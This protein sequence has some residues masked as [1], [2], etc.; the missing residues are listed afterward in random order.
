LF[1]LLQL[2]I[3]FF[4]FK[5]E[6]WAILHFLAPD[7][8]TFKC[9]EKFSVGFDLSKGFFISI[10]LLLFL[11]FLLLLLSFFFLLYYNSYLNYYLFNLFYLVL[12]LLLLFF[13]ILFILKFFLIYENRLHRFKFTKKSKKTVKFIHAASFKRKRKHKT[14]E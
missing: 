9:I 3:I 4:F 6:L 11:L 13:L 1:S 2:F 12:I 10:L 5:K 7:I 8:F 14:A